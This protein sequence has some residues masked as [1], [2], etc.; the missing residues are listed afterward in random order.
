[1]RDLNVVAEQLFNEIR[2][3]F[4]S[5]TIG[6]GEGNGPGRFYRILTE[7]LVGD[8]AQCGLVVGEGC[9]P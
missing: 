2:G 4:P 8:A 7:A 9:T 5:V 6:D 1:M 3:R